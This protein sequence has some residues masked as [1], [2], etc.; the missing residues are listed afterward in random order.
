MRRDLASNM[1]SVKL[2]IRVGRVTVPAPATA[3]HHVATGD[4]TL[5]HLSQV[6][7]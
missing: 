6:N 1:G 7:S 2:G 3:E 4:R 5:V